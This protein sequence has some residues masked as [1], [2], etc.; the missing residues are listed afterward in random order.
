MVRTKGMDVD[1]LVA[2]L[3]GANGHDERKPLRASLRAQGAGI[4]PRLVAHLKHTDCFLRW[5][6]VSLLGEFAHS[7]TAI[8]VLAFALGEDEVHARWRSFWAVS[9]FPSSVLLPTLLGALQ[10]PDDTCAWRAALILSMLRQSAAVP[11]L[12][13]GL[14]SDDEWIRWEAISAL[15]SIGPPNIEN[16]IGA[17]LHRDQPRSIRQEAALALGNLPGD[18][19]TDWLDKALRDRHP[20]VR[21]RAAMSLAKRG[22]A[23]DVP[24]LKERLGQETDAHVLTEIQQAIHR[25]ERTHGKSQS[26][27][28]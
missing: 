15:K 4:A 24:R 19:A 2:A 7:D 16:N 5:E 6:M 28:A 23:K 10:A 17:L 26:K 25:L 20:Q 18:T 8:D 11:V 21:W 1:N 13:G 12:V 22:T 9:C 3:A 27:V 14:T